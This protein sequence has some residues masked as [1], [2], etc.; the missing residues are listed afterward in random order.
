[1]TTFDVQNAK[2]IKYAASQRLTIY[3][4]SNLSPGQGYTQV[5][6]LMRDATTGHREIHSLKLSLSLTPATYCHP[7]G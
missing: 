5:W 4:Y 3:S 2:L 7:K 1:M 6:N